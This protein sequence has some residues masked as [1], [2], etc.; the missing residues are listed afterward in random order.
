VTA[1]LDSAIVGETEIQGQVKCAYESAS[2]YNQL[3]YE[4]HY[5]FQKALKIGKQIRSSFPAKPGLPGLEHAVYNTGQHKFKNPQDLK[6]LFFGVSDINCKILEYFKVRNFT[7]ITICNRTREHAEELAE[8]HKLHVLPWTEMTKCWE[9]DW[10]I[11]GTKF[12]D[13]LITRK[14]IPSQ[15]IGQKLV[16]DLSVP[17]NVDPVVGK[18]SEITLLNIDQ[19]NRLLKIRKQK[20]THVIAST[21]KM[22]VSETKQQIL[23]FKQKERYRQGKLPITA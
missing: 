10:L 19:I 1:G 15:A 21:E 12:P 6:V 7:N 14:E 13:Y 23:I 17:R 4:L 2:E 16:M 5:M 9:Y 20:M 18:H 22:V 8:Q 11:F 3:N